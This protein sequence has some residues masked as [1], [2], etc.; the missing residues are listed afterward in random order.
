M[1]Y[2]TGSISLSAKDGRLLEIVGTATRITHQQLFELARLKLIEVK[3][4]VYDWRVRRLVT[5]SLLKK[6]KTLFRGSDRVYSITRNGISGLQQLGIHLVSVYVE[7]KDDEIQHQIQH[8]LEL[9]R[10]HIALLSS[11]VLSRWTP[12]K[13]L[14]ALNMAPPFDY[15]KYYDAVAALYMDDQ[16]LEIAIEYEHTLK[17]PVTRYAAVK[18]KLEKEE[19]AD[20]IM[21]VMPTE[22]IS[23]ALRLQLRDL[24]K[25]IL[26]VD[27]Q[28]LVSQRLD[29]RVDLNYLMLTLRDALKQIAEQKKTNTLTNARGI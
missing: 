17:R 14:Q 6:N 3:K 8:T 26:L 2:I 23:I 1:R 10:I 21:F 20:A 7:S 19:R 27:L 22:E 18:A 24:R 4:Q 15:A 9:N 12:A 5:H 25:H 28:D 16:R 11:G 13:V 29:A